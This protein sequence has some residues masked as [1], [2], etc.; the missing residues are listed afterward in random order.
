MDRPGATNSSAAL[1]GNEEAHDAA[2]D[3]LVRGVGGSV[4]SAASRARPCRPCGTRGRTPGAQ[5]HA[6]PSSTVIRPSFHTCGVRTSRQQMSSS[7]GNASLWR[8][9]SPAGGHPSDVFGGA[10]V[11]VLSAHTLRGPDRAVHVTFPDVGRSR[12]RPSG[13]DPRGV[14]ATVVPAEQPGGWSRQAAAV[15]GFGRPVLLDVV[16]GLSCT[17]SV[18]RGEVIEHLSASAGCGV[19]VERAGIVDQGQAGERYERTGIGG[20]DV[21]HD[22]CRA[23]VGDGGPDRPRSR[24]HGRP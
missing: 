22:A 23:G 3:L 9:V 17:G 21:E 4:A 19:G 10:T 14:S 6:P 24:H 20:A 5:T 15:P 1:W 2:A 16:V 11:Q 18:E 12:H 7:S 8:C 13:W